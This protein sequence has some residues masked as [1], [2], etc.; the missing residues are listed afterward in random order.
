MEL[1]HGLEREQLGAVPW[2]F[3]GWHFLVVA[4]TY[5]NAME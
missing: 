1:E 2:H 3:V 5:E 4:I